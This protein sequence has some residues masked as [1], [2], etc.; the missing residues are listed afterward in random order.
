MNGKLDLAWV[1]GPV[2]AQAP[3]VGKQEAAGDGEEEEGEVVEREDDG[4][5]GMEYEL[6]DDEAWGEID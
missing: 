1:S 2:P 5:V 6:A 4:P 3:A